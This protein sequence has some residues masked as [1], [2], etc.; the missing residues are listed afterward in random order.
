M[1]KITLVDGLLSIEGGMSMSGVTIEMIKN[2]REVL[3]TLSALC[4]ALDGTPALEI[5]EVEVKYHQAQCLL[6][7]LRESK[8][9]PKESQDE[10]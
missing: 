2:L 10:L 4:A 5:P 3:S 7:Y 1:H 8:K 9:F 6:K